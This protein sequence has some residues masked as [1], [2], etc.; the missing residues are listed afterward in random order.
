M[1]MRRNLATN[2]SSLS[3]E[4]EELASKTQLSAEESERFVEVQNQLKE[5]IPDWWGY[6][7]F[8]E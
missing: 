1:P 7:R 5:L 4:Y 2:M 6:D 8:N 3:A